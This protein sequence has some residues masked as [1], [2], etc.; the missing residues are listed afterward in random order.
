MA[1]AFQPAFDPDPLL[2]RALLP[3]RWPGAAAR[4]LLL[5]SRRRA[6]ALRTAQGRPRLF[7]IFAHDTPDRTPE[8]DTP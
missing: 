4:A 3:R 5:E 1:V 8:E 6:L 2:P 7:Q